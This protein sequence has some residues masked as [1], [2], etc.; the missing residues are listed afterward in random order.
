[1]RFLGVIFGAGVVCGIAGLAIGVVLGWVWER[2]HRLRRRPSASA[3]GAEARGSTGSPAPVSAPVPALH[4][5][6]TVRGS[7]AP[8]ATSPGPLESGIRIEAAGIDAAAFMTLARRVA[9][10]EYDAE[11]VA[12]ALEKSINVGAWD[13]VRLVGALRVLS[14]GYLF[15]A[16]PGMLVDPE[17]HGR[18][19]EAALLHYSRRLLPPTATMIWSG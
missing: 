3:T 4:V 1:M 16:A 13:G 9:A 15:A 18:G 12:R 19:I 8:P 2:V 7:S 6:A 11:S 5:A 10:N 14:D 17:Y